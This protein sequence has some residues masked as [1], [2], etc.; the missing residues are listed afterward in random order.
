M[1][2]NMYVSISF[3]L[4]MYLFSSNYKNPFALLSFGWIFEE[5][6]QNNNNNCD[7]E[8]MPAAYQALRYF[9]FVSDLEDIQRSYSWTRVF[10]LSSTLKSPGMTDT[11]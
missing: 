1:Q 11:S 4:E 5:F 8:V 3:I 2:V 7:N 10:L 6:F 9:N